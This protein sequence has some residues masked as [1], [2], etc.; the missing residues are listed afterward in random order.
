MRNFHP[1][2]QVTSDPDSGI[3]LY[4]SSVDAP[5]KPQVAMK[6]EGSYIAFSVSHGPMEMA[7]RPR[8]DEL[9]RVLGRVSP[10]PGLQTT[11]QVGTSDAYIALGLNPDGTLLMRPTL[12]ADA[13]GHFCFN[14]IMSDEM[15]A[16][17][18]EWLGVTREN[19]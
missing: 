15:R 10:V 3:L 11:R 14:L 19:D 8:V 16:S 12:V 9:Q 13:T 5:F 2:D 4:T 17:L 18:F 7:L 6:R 1:L